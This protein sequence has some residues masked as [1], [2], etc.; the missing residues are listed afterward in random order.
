MA[1]TETGV[2]EFPDATGSSFDHGAFDPETRRV[3]VSHT[4]RN[5][6][7]VIDHDLQR[8]PSTVEGFSGEG[9]CCC[10]VLVTNR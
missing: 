1:L 10:Q 8:H 2:I 5:R 6:V 3:F 7:E 9:R 4:G